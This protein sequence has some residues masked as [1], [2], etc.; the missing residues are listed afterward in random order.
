MFCK[1]CKLS[2]HKFIDCLKIECMYCHKRGHILDNCPKRPSQPPGMPTKDKNFTKSG[3]SSVIAATSDDSNSPL[4]ISDL[5][6]LLNQLISSSSA[7]VVSPGNRW[8]LDSAYCNHMISYFSLMSTSSPAKSLPS[9]YVADGNCINIS[10]T[11][12]INTSN[13]HLPQTYC[14]P[15]LTFNIVYWSIM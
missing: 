2:G 6:S 8:L 14:V 1:N 12:T 5:Q 7:L 15:N 13:L 11:G 9:I 3:T 4:Q 10:H